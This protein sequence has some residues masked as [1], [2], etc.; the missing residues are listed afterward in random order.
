MKQGSFIV[1]FL[2][3]EGTILYIV[4]SVN[5]QIVKFCPDSSTLFKFLEETEEKVYRDFNNCD[6]HGKA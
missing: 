6:S 4:R 2:L 5:G 1:E 3:D